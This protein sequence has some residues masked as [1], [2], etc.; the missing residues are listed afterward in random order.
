M[1]II[2]LK[3]GYRISLSD[4]EFEALSLLVEYGTEADEEQRDEFLALASSGAKRALKGRFALREP[5]EIDEDRRH[6]L[7]HPGR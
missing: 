3:R 7:R 2:R 5:M 6:P 4:G 1:K